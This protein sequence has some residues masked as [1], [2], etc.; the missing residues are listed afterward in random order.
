MPYIGRHG[1][2]SNLI[3]AGGHAMLGVSAA[4]ATGKLV[5]EIIGHKPPA[6]PLE[7]FRPDRFS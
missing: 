3:Y 4:A 2:F 6:I 1:K 7:A 5:D